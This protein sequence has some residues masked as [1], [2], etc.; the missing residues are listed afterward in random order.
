MTYNNNCFG[1]SMM[2]RDN[3]S[4]LSMAGWIVAYNC[5]YMYSLFAQEHVQLTPLCMW[6]EQTKLVNVNVLD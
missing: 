2:Y 4:G 6:K 1:Y 5:I 3:C